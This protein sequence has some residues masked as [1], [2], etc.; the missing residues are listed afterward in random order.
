MWEHSL[1]EVKSKKKPT[2]K[3]PLHPNKAEFI[4]AKH[5]E[6]QFVLKSTVSPEDLNL[7]LHSS[8]RTSNIDTS[9]RL[10]AQ[11]A[12]PN[13]LHPEKGTRAL[14]VAAK[15]GQL[16]QIELLA[17]YGADPN[18]KDV[19]G[20]TAMHIAKLSGHREVQ[21]RLV[22]MLYTVTDRLI[23]FLTRLR[24][25]HQ[26]G[27]HFVLPEPRDC[28]VNPSPS[29]IGKSRLSQLNNNQFEEFVM[30]V[31][32]EVDRRETETIW[33]SSGASLE[34]SSVPFLPVDPDLSSMRNQGRQKL[35]RLSTQEF[36]ALI[37]DILH[38]AHK[39]QNTKKKTKDTEEEP[40]YDSV[41]SDDDYATVEQL[42]IMV[43]QNSRGLPL[44]LSEPA[45]STIAK[46]ETS[47]EREL[48]EKLL[49]AQA[50]E[51]QLSV[52]IQRLNKR[53][54]EVNIENEKLKRSLKVSVAQSEPDPVM[55]LRPTSQNSLPSPRPASMYEP[56]D[57]IRVQSVMPLPEEVI[58][59]TNQVTKRIQEL[60]S[61]VRPPESNFVYVP[62]A[63]RI[64]VAVAELTAIFPQ[65]LT[66][67][68]IRSWMYQ[69]NTSTTRLQF[70]CTELEKCAESVRSLAF[71]IADANRRLITR[72]K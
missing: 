71:Q 2:P 18:A 40:L 52:Q 26:A 3:D 23:Y 48:R 17:I 67:D 29:D 1:G 31:Y 4:R 11:G 7:Q 24:P 10:L 19:H 35:A 61:A 5:K 8:V 62:C 27:Q 28:L 49:I 68:E 20:N 6:L 53:V 30:D 59:R 39:R 54:D 45:K 21:M 69:L 60:W 64:R 15:A 47:L 51:S 57:A 13:F 56:R 46:A 70:E 55:E 72:F 38:D 36:S 34:Y 41:A 65:K 12:D 16:S 43:A 66:D 25:D 50:R 9:L 58:R 44:M 42:A 32:D 33:L 22:E 63:E 14:H 37:L